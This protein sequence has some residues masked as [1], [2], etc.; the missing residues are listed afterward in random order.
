MALAEDLA[1]FF[2]D[3]GVPVDFAGAPSGLLGHL[4]VADAIT[5][6]KDGLAGVVGTARV[7]LVPTAALRHAATEAKLLACEDPIVVDGVDYTV[8][9]TAQLDDGQLTR[10]YLQDVD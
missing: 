7:V 8:R 1:P 2:A 9:Y 10:I 3:F 6:E 4:D 5:A